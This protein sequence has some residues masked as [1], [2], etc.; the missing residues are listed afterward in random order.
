M[1]PNTQTLDVEKMNLFIKQ[2]HLTGANVSRPFFFALAH[3]LASANSGKI[4]SQM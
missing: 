3:L 4:N 1:T 2:T